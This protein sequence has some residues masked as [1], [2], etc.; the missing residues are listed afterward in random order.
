M[1]AFTLCENGESRFTIVRPAGA[2]AATCAAAEELQDYL[3]RVTGCTL[4]IRTDADAVCAPW[5]LVGNPAVENRFAAS[6]ASVASKMERDSVFVAAREDTVFLSGISGRGTR[7]AVCTFLEDACGIRWFTET[8]TKIPTCSTLTVEPVEKLYTPYMFYRQSCAKDGTEPEFAVHNRINAGAVLD[9]AHG[10]AD[11]FAEGAFV[12]TI[13]Q[14]IPDELFETHPEYFPLIDGERRCA[15][16]HQR[17]LTNPDVRRIAVEWTKK[18]FRENPRSRIVSVSQ[19]DTYPEQ[20]NECRCPSCLAVNEREG[21]L[22]GTMLELVNEVADAVKDEFPD[23][24]VETLAYRFTRQLP[25]QL[26]PRDNVIIRL[27]SIECCFSHPIITCDANTLHGAEPC[28][29]ADFLKD[30]AEWGAAAKQLFVWD[31]VINFA[32]YQAPNAN[33]D[34][35]APNMQLFRDSKVRGYYP[36]GAYDT[37][38]SDFSELRSYLLARLAWDA[39]FPVDVATREFLQETCG[40]G[41][42]AVYRYLRALQDRVKVL[43]WHMFTY[44]TPDRVLWTDEFLADCEACFAEA[45]EAAEDEVKKDFIRKLHL[46]LWYVKLRTCAASCY[47]SCKEAQEDADRYGALCEHFGIE[48]MSEGR[49]MASGVARLKSSR[50]PPQF[51]LPEEPREK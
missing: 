22:M 6:F 39:T 3:W 23:C 33:L 11:S 44:K 50:I 12:H 30:L 45:L 24:Y 17:C 7:Y 13:G 2:D 28:S 31:Y 10:G 37:R 42:Q 35:I 46:S 26:R 21:S 41:W 1:K 43:N 9:E 34:T 25:K 36:E 48:R 32:H 29:C 27:C 49:S 51:G 40:R 16:Y 14:I 18:K 47:A 5:I 15:K 38:G 4:P 20:P 8:V 19:A